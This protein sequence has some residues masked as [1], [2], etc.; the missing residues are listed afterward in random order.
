MVFV[1]EEVFLVVWWSVEDGEEEV[2]VMGW[3][4]F[5]FFIVDWCVFCYM[6]K[7]EVFL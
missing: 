2:C 7:C 4:V 1:E 6:M 5:Y 3:F